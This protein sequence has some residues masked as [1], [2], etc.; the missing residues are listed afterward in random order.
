MKRF[1]NHAYNIYNSKSLYLTLFKFIFNNNLLF[2]A[3]SCLERHVNPLV[4][5]AFAF[6]STHQSALGP[7]GGLWPIPLTCNGIVLDKEGR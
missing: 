1:R 2:G 3:P 4:P 7:R 5:A 6:V